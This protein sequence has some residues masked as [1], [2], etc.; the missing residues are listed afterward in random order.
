MCNLSDEEIK[1]DFVRPENI[2]MEEICMKAI[3]YSL[4]L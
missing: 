3:K 2:P 1:S 4:E